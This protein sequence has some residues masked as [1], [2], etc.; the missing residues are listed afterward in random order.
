[1]LSSI[2]I[3]FPSRI[4]V[5]EHAFPDRTSY[6]AWL[7]D[8][9]FRTK[10]DNVRANDHSASPFVWFSSKAS[11]EIDETDLLQYLGGHDDTLHWCRMLLQPCVGGDDGEEED[12]TAQMVDDGHTNDHGYDYDLCVIGG[13]SGGMAAA[14]E[15]ASLG[16]KVVLLDFVKPSPQGTTWGLGG[17]C[18]NGTSCVCVDQVYIPILG[19]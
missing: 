17:T 18:V 1:V 5:V 4:K 15:A 7:I 9:G 6:R 14:K 16:A 3:L 2:S 12:M 10:F 19:C 8:G 13:G 11:E